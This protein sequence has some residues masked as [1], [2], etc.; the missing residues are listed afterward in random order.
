MV[1]GG[2][3]RAGGV[4]PTV[5]GGSGRACACLPTVSGGSG[6]PMV[7]GG[8]GR[9]GGG[10]PMVSGS[11]VGAVCGSEIGSTAGPRVTQNT[12]IQREGGRVIVTSTRITETDTESRVSEEITE[13]YEQSNKI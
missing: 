8:S 7:S 3:G 4:L 10:L 6:L 5:S 11:S 1:S 12:S 9:S 2:S 13:T